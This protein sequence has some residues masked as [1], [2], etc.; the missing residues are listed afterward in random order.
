MRAGCNGY[1]S[2]E[3]IDKMVRLY[4][5][6][7]VNGDMSLTTLAKRLGIGLNTLQYHLKKEGAK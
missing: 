4:R 5:S 2:R 3:I 7:V 1:I 6:E